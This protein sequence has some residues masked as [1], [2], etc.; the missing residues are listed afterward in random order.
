MLFTA[1]TEIDAP[2]AV[3]M[4]ALTDFE[5]WERAAMRR[6]AEVAR[7]DAMQSPG[8]GMVWDVAFPFRGKT[9]QVDL[10]LVAL[11]AGGKMGFAGAGKAFDGDMEVDLVP[12]APGRTRLLVKA[13]VRPLTLGSRLM[14]QSLKLARGKVQDKLDQRL[15]Q[16]A[17]DIEARQGSAARGLR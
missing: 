4:T 17:R 9:R 7:A 14:L 15:A 8:P 11:D 16:F 6:G 1:K 12:L 13:D 2:L 5:A 3:V 10:K